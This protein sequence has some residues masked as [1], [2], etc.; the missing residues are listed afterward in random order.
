M[1]WRQWQ[2]APAE[3]PCCIYRQHLV[4]QGHISGRAGDDARS[5]SVIDQWHYLVSAGVPAAP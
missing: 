4:Q 5:V 1:Q 3:P 2:A